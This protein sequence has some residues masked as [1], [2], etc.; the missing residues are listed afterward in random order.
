MPN[1]GVA[2]LAN[3]NPAP[4]DGS[5]SYGVDFNPAADALRITSTAGQNLRT[6]FATANAATIVDT[7]LTR[8]SAADPAARESALGVTAAGYTNNDND[9]TTGTA[10]LVLDTQRD[11]LGNQ[12][13][14][15]DG[16][17][18][19]IGPLQVNFAAATAGFDVS[20]QGATNSGFA[21]TA[22]SLYSVNLDTG[23]A[24]LVKRLGNVIDLAIPTNQG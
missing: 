19:F 5:G 18:S 3:T 10:L 11:Q 12:A 13:P 21:V 23:Q 24:T 4:L 14:A 8:P 9:T 22:G 16:T 15:N 2:A 1:T 6:P 17:I 20:T 7:P